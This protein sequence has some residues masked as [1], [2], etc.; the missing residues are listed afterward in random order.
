[1]SSRGHSLRGLFVSFEGGEGCGKD[2]HHG[3]LAEHLKF[4]GYDVVCG[5]EPGTTEFGERMRKIVMDPNIPHVN[6]RTE[7][8]LYTAARSELVT[9]IVEPTLKRGGIVL[10]NR[11]KDSSKAYQGYGGET[12]LDVVDTINNF[13]IHGINP[14]L[15][16]L[17]DITAE[18]GLKRLSGHEFKGAQ[19]DKIEAR[20]PEYHQ[21]VNAGYRAMA[22]QEPDRFRVITYIYE[23]IDQMQSEIR[24]HVDAYIREHGLDSTLARTS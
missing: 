18:E 4:L 13:A 11:F 16:F 1:M 17:L 15:T 14:D 20:G 8:L 23:G 5:R 9:Q 12:P 21:I 3:L 6:S 10:L 22:A 19:R 24:R 7:L 2:T